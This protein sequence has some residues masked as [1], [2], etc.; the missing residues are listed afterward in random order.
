MCNDR[1]ICDRASSYVLLIRS[2]LE[3]HLSLLGMAEQYCRMRSEDYDLMSRAWSKGKPAYRMWDACVNNGLSCLDHWTNPGNPHKAD[4]R[5]VRT[6]LL[7]IA[8]Q[9]ETEV[10][11]VLMP[12]GADPSSERDT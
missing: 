10:I 1:D 4:E 5:F 11:R 8:V 9:L 7:W 6:E 2:Y 12:S 3:G